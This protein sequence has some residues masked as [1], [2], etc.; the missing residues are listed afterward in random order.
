MACD[1][2]KVAALLAGA[3]EVAEG[4][5][6]ETEAATDG[7]VAESVGSPGA[8]LADANAEAQT[9]GTSTMETWQEPR[10]PAA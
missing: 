3:L 1:D 4:R 9:P 8:R 10:A 6:G 5:M 2:A 7:A